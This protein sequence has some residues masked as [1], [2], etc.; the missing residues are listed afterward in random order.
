M[1]RLK[2]LNLHD[3]IYKPRVEFNV[4]DVNKYPI[5]DAV[6]RRQINK[7]ENIQILDLDHLTTLEMKELQTT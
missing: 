4:R 5:Q 1:N 7:Q 3:A 6:R 2:K